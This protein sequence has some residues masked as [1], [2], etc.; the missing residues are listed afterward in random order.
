[1]NRKLEIYIHQSNY[2]PLL[3]CMFVTWKSIRA[4][5]KF[6]Y[7]L[8]VEQF[9]IYLIGLWLNNLLKSLGTGKLSQL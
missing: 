1:M 3:I 6:H 9:A 2:K 5:V 4:I 7:V 8:S